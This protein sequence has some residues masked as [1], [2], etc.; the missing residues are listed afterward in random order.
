MGLICSEKSLMSSSSDPL[1][2][3]R[4]EAERGVTCSAKSHIPFIEVS[5]SF[6][7]AM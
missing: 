4:M 2:Q 7:F 3:V 5:E 6:E 1:N